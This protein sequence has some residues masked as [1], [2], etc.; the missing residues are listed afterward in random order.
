[1][2]I[3][4][5][6]VIIL[7]GRGLDVECLSKNGT[8]VKGRDGHPKSV[9]FYSNYLSE[10]HGI[11]QNAL[12]QEGFLGCDPSLDL[13]AQKKIKRISVVNSYVFHS[14]IA[15]KLIIKFE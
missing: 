7:H 8:L 10:L 14:K 15:G 3:R 1:M 11:W 2:V 4:T 6:F 9:V 5:K 13:A 12:K